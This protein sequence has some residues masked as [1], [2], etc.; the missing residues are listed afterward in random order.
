MAKNPD[1][2]GA[3]WEKTGTK[4]PYMSGNVEGVGKVV[5]FRNNKKQNPREPDWRILRDRPK[6]ERTAANRFDDHAEPP[7]RA[8]SLSDRLLANLP[9]P[10]RVD[11]PNDDI[12]F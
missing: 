1:E 2:L 12:P 11:D 6:E 3:L 4:G 5:V 8:G 9:R 7:P 10:S